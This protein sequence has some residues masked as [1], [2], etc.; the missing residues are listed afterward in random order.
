MLPYYIYY[1]PGITVAW[2]LAGVSHKKVSD[3]NPGSCL[4]VWS[5]LASLQVRSFRPKSKNIHMGLIGDTTLPIRMS[6]SVHGR[7]STYVA[8]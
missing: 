2:W 5:C 8:L 7:L 6:V 4:P 3:S 1:I